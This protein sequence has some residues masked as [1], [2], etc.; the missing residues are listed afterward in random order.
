MFVRGMGESRTPMQKLNEFLR[1]QPTTP[2]RTNGH[3]ARKTRP[4]EADGVRVAVTGTSTFDV[5]NPGLGVARALREDPDVSRIYGLSYGTFDSGVYAHGLFDAAFRLP[6][7]SGATQLL[8]RIREIHATHP[9]D[10]LI[11]CLDGELRIS[12]RSRR[13]S[14]GSA[15]KRCCPVKRRC[16]DAAKYAFFDGSTQRRLGLLQHPNERGG[17]VRP[18]CERALAKT[19]LPAVV[20]GPISEC[21]KVADP[22]EARAA[23]EYFTALGCRASHRATA[24][25]WTLFRHR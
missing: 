18:W 11:P 10:V 24:G 9:F 5:I 8:N 7:E 4:G 23:C 16:D 3:G 15:S 12:S 1:G 14:L 21:Q 17:Q 6:T 20:K 19:G 13:S 22:D 25:C 2:R